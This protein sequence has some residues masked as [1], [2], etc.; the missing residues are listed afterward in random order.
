MQLMRSQIVGRL[1]EVPSQRRHGCDVGALPFRR[2]CLR[3]PL[4]ESDSRTR[5]KDIL[6]RKTGG[7]F[8][9]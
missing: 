2:A 3:L 7:T 4:A 9:L 8:M 6:I 5:G 1:A